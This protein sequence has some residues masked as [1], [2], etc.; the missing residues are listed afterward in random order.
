M[1]HE[2]TLFLIIEG[3]LKVLKLDPKKPKVTNPN[4]SSV[5]R[6]HDGQRGNRQ[7]RCFWG[8]KGGFSFADW[9]R[10]R[11]CEAL[12]S[13][14]RMHLPSSLSLA[15]SLCWY[16]FTT[17]H[18]SSEES[19]IRLCLF[20]WNSFFSSFFNSLSD[21]STCGVAACSREVEAYWTCSTTTELRENYFSLPF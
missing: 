16:S 21:F 8:R 4:K 19:A 20:L 15:R 14:C 13:A 2:M 10:Q 1:K 18:P 9:A 12:S 3:N 5:A 7:T 11:F 6:N 17:S